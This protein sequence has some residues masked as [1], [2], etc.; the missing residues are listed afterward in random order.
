MTTSH[1]SG[2]DPIDSPIRLPQVTPTIAETGVPKSGGPGPASGSLL[3]VK[4]EHDSQGG[5][6]R[7]PE[8]GQ[9]GPAGRFETAEEEK[10]RLERERQ[11][12]GSSNTNPGPGPENH[13]EDE[14]Q[15][16]PYKEF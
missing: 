16:P 1:T 11:A 4:A 15:L 13:G 9:S 7:V 5:G 8:P 14:D 6:G 3:E 12:G 2:S 10:R